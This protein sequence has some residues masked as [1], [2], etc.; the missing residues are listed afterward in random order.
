MDCNQA[1][2]KLR[3]A[4]WSRHVVATQSMTSS[5]PSMPSRG[6]LPHNAPRLCA[7]RCVEDPMTS[8]HLSI[9]AQ[10]TGKRQS[11]NS[12]RSTWL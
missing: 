2:I 10:V 1:K 3:A 5:R 12:R 8:V 7:L 9:S 6:M 4:K 11:K